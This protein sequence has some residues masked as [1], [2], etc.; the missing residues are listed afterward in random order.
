M[1]KLHSLY[2]AGYSVP[3]VR[4]HKAGLSPWELY[5]RID[6]LSPYSFFLDS[7]QYEPPAQRYSYLGWRPF[8]RVSF[9][10]GKLILEGETSRTWKTLNL[11]RE[12]RKLLAP[13]R[14]PLE[15]AS[16]F[17]TGGAVGYFGYELADQFDRVKFRPK[18]GPLI[19]RLGLL[20][21]RDVVVFDHKEEAYHLISWL[22]PQKGLTFRK[23]LRKAES[24]LAEMEG[25]FSLCGP[26][27]SNGH[28]HLVDFHPEISQATFQQMVARTKRYIEAGDIYQANLSQRFSFEFQGSPLKLYGRLRETNPSPFSAVLRWNDL[29]VASSSPEL[30]V[31]KRG[32]DCVTCP[33]AGTRPR[34]RRAGETKRLARELLQSEKERAEHLM[35]VDLE[36]ND[37]GRVSEWRSVRVKEF[38]RLEKYARVIH[39]VSEITSKLR[40]SKD[41]WDL[42]QAVFPG[43]TITGCPKIRSMEIIDELEPVE[44]GVYTG[45]IGYVGFDGNLKLNIAIR[46]LVLLKNRG[47]LQV[48]AGIVADSDPARE[49]EETLHKGEALAEAILQASEDEES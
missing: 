2:E 43:G 46:T 49:Y 10:G 4:P 33:M 15:F 21:F 24:R 9:K 6:S 32:R 20:L 25:A 13:F 35:L 5:Q 26:E 12:L 19:P 36:R 41:A 30:L 23:A 14:V 37:L 11:T 39:I 28:F 16:D 45:S 18:K 44:R 34:G 8:L 47:Y 29:F 7:L 42:I 3:L 27:S 48:G 31:E 17:F 38:M 1:R 40:P 22:T